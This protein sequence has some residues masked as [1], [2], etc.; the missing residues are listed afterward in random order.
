MTNRNILLKYLFLAVLLTTVFCSCTKQTI[1]SGTGV[2]KGKISIGPI[3]PVETVPPQPQCLPTIQTYKTWATA[4][5]TLDKKT[6]IA[7]LDPNLDGTYQL[8]LP[9]GYYIIDFD[10]ARSNSVGGSNLPSTI[11]ISDKD[12]TSL[13]I[14]IDT[15]IR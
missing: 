3:C 15:G 1:V 5:W 8:S 4:V 2:L 7:T 12:T 9:S 13:D 6:K 11:S 10:V 14:T